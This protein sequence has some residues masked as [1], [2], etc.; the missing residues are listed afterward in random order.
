M[1]QL[2][3]ILARLASLILIPFSFAAVHAGNLEKASFENAPNSLND[4]VLKSNKAIAPGLLRGH[5]DIQFCAGMD[6]VEPVLLSHLSRSQDESGAS[7]EVFR[8]LD[9]ATPIKRDSHSNRRDNKEFFTSHLA[10]D[11]GLGNG[12]FPIIG[13]FSIERKG[14][15]DSPTMLLIGMGLIGLAACGGRK[16]FKRQ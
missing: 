1:L 8:L 9:R 13:P 2:R 5:N 4:T 11:P 16:K 6:L 12:P 7:S 10:D 3:T 15:P 14:L